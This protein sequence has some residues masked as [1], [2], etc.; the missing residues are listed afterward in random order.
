MFNAMVGARQRTGNY[1]GVT[2][3]ADQG[4]VRRGAWVFEVVDLPGTYSL[5]SDSQDERVVR[6]ALLA[7]AFDAVVD[8]TD[9]SH[10]ERH[11]YLAVELLEL[12]MPL[13]IA[14]NLW[15]RVSVEGARIEVGLLSLLLGVPVVPTSGRSGEGIDRLL[16]AVGQLCEKRRGE[17]WPLLHVDYGREIERA[18]GW[19][20]P[21]A[22]PCVAAPQCTRWCAL[23]VL[24]GGG[25]CLQRCRWC[26]LPQCPHLCE[27]AAQSR[28]QIERRSGEEIGM[29]LARR[30]YDYVASLCAQV[31]TEPARA[32][33]SPSERADR[34][35]LSRW[36][37]LPLFGLIMFLVF[38]LTFTLAQPLVDAME[39]GLSGLRRGMASW[40]SA[41]SESAWRSLWVDG[42]LGGVGNVAI[43]VPNILLLFLCLAVLEQSGYM[44]RAMFLLDRWLHRLGLPGKGF[45]PMLIGF[46]CTVPAMM[47]TRTLASREDR[48]TTM[49][50]L[51]LISCSA[52][53][54]IYTL[55]LSAFFPLTCQ[56]PLL[57]G[58]YL[59]GIVL[60]VL[61]ARLLRATVFQSPPPPFI[62]EVPPYRMPPLIELLRQVWERTWAFLKNAGTLILALSVLL[63]ALSVWPRLPTRQLAP[64]LRERAAAR[65]RQDLTGEQR[66]QLV[67]ELDRTLARIKLEHS[68]MGRV[69]Q[70][71][72]PVFEP[73]GFD[74]K[75]TT[76]LLGA[77]VAKE[78]L[79]AQL[80]V[81]HSVGHGAESSLTLRE[82]LRQHYTPL[83]G[84]CLILFC[85]IGTPCMATFAIFKQESGTWKWPLLQA[86]GLTALAY[87][88]TL[89]VYRLG[90]C[91][92]N[93]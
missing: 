77:F 80:A 44:V 22:E 53:L 83:Q 13:V 6:A 81:V 3:A 68:L 71:L 49:L 51:P 26:R 40:W 9:A 19:L 31:V 39:A 15:D 23:N 60:A 90:T 4:R 79:L 72:A 61:G 65:E 62:M 46:G 12:G 52:R 21:L 30:R 58:I 55:I 45:I 67:R 57:W 64:L 92:L 86:A 91:L 11:L 28:A 69:G 50:V 63:W 78:V 75:I 10:L 88:I 84:L 47:A 20:G 2:V 37:G 35:L 17:L 29:T 36:L 82:S 93:L 59:T 43:F 5:L 54:P 56:A 42:V 73:L 34:I 70:G 87:G 16:A 32:E 48:L 89:V 76:A 33:P 24:E 74:G 27:E 38:Q 25:P 85:L 14:L 18:V 1:P 8:V 41:G 7:D 66:Q